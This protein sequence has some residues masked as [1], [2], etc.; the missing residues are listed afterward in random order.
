ME[1]PEHVD[2][3]ISLGDFVLDLDTR[4]LRRGAARIA[5]SPK[6]FQLLAILA[7]H[8]PKALSK[9]ELLARL[10]PDAFVVDK[11]LTNLIGELRE[12]LGD[13]ATNPRFLRTVQRYGYALQDPEN[14]S[15]PAAGRFRLVWTGGR[16]VLHDGDHLIGRD[17]NLEL[18][19]DHASVS[20]HHARITIA[21][22]DAAIAD[23]GSKNGTFVGERR[24]V[25]S[26]ALA[27]GD[28]IR[29]GAVRLTFQAIRSVGS[30]ETHADA[31]RSE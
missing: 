26:T 5:L 11:N 31:P 20:R 14:R 8:R 29:V 21:G 6:A 15:S 25:S 2:G 27:D 19:F 22:S 16:A 23:L 10:W 12:A 13:T 3:R 18:F 28:V 9:S 1:R 7:A 17:P 4:E 30:T 24:V